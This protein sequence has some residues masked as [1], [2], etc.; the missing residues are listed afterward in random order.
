ME[1]GFVEIMNYTFR[2]KGDYE[3]GKTQYHRKENI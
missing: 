3:L 1:E 2:E